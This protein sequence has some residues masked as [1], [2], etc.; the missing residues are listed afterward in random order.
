[1]A[2]YY[3]QLESFFVETVWAEKALAII[4]KGLVCLRYPRS[5]SSLADPWPCS[6]NKIVALMP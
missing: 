3:V 4:R 6:N 1:M 5:F 2:F